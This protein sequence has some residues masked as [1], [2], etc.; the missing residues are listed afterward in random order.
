MVS[1]QSM[2]DVYNLIDVSPAFTFQSQ[3]YNKSWSRLDR[4]YLCGTNWC[5]P[6]LTISVH[7]QSHLYDHF[8]IALTLPEYDWK[9]QMQH[10]Y[11]KRPLM[12]NNLHL[13]KPLFS[14]YV[15]NLLSMVR[16]TPL[17]PVQKWQL[18]T[19]HMQRVI[20]ITGKHYASKD[21]QLISM[22]TSTLQ[23]LRL[24]ANYHPLTTKENQ[25]IR[26]CLEGLRYADEQA[27]SKARFLSHS[28]G[29]QDINAVSKAF[30]KKLGSNQNRTALASI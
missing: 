11:A 2:V 27:A 28:H 29:M 12:I 8:P 24:K 14:D 5:P 16:E 22:P 1:T 10:C 4:F 18:I 30:F 7:S 19:E 6:T 17:L 9:D 25:Q 15:T 3:A 26:G 13:S 23:A 20:K 21:R